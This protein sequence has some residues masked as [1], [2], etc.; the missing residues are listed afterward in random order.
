MVVLYQ[1]GMTNGS[2]VPYVCPLCSDQLIHLYNQHELIDDGTWTWKTEL[3]H[4]TFL[5]PDAEAILNIPIRTG[6]GEDLFDWAFENSGVYS[7]KSA[8]S[9]LENQKA[10][11]ALQEG[12]VTESSEKQKQLS[13]RLW[14]L[15]VVPKVCV[16]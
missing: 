3:V 6:G 8:Y 7:V 9:A 11:L 4:E 1:F 15:K 12:T 14:K 10:R 5:A 2:Q 16:F 13:T